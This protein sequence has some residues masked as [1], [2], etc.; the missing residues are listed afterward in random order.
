MPIDK[1]TYCRRDDEPHL[2]DDDLASKVSRYIQYV[3]LVDTTHLDVIAIGRTIILSGY[4]SNEAEVGCVEQAA[5]S[6]IG[7][8]LVENNVTVRHH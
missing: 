5:A 3:A 7:V 1:Q 4:V 6:V 2:R 8:H